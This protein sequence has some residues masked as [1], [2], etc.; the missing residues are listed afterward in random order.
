MKTT[1]RLAVATAAAALALAAPAQASWFLSK[2]AAEQAARHT[3]SQKY[4]DTGVIARCRPYAR[5][6]A[7]PAYTY[8]RW[9]C[10][11]AGDATFTDGSPALCSGLLSIAG[12]HYYPYQWRVLR[13]ERC[14]D[15][16]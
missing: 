16:P 6:S 9:V 15:R 4:G 1:S 10:G 3:A 12:S 13:G 7:D 8:H 14:R 5:E 2:R 11:W